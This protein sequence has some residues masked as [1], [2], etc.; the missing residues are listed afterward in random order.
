MIGHISRVGKYRL[1][2]YDGQYEVLSDRTYSVVVDLDSPS[3][4]GILDRQLVA[5]VREAT[6]ANEPMDVPR[7][8][9]CDWLTGVKVMDWTGA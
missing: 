9:V 2:V 6:A 4:S 5:L 1:R 3:A 7:L 8:E